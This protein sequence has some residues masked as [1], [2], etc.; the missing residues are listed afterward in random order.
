[1]VSKLDCFRQRSL[2]PLLSRHSTAVLVALFA[3]G[4]GSGIKMPAY[5]PEQLTGISEITI[6]VEIEVWE[7]RA[8]TA[9]PMGFMQS[10]SVSMPEWSAEAREHVITAVA[11]SFSNEGLVVT[12]RD[13]RPRVPWLPDVYATV[14]PIEMPTCGLFRYDAEAHLEV[15]AIQVVK[16][17]GLRAQSWVVGLWPPSLVV[18]PLN[19]SGYAGYFFGAGH[20]EVR[21]CL[22]QPGISGPAWAYAERFFGGLDL[23]DPTNARQLAERAHE[24]YRAAVAKRGRTLQ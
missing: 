8:K 11:K 3:A 19:P 10:D 14:S 16:S 17:T 21:F 23:R 13:V 24:H 22:F 6:T 7:A 9:H 15:V 2:R 12:V 18:A 4:C 1:M 5:S 20:T